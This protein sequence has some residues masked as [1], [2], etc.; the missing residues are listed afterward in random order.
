MEIKT[1][2]D[3]EKIVEQY[4]EIIYKDGNSYFIIRKE[5]V[6]EIEK[7]LYKY[8]HSEEGR[9]LDYELAQSIN[10]PEIYILVFFD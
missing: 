3:I 10:E 5:L 6:S 8:S 4:K 7:W 2:Q 9:W 1:T